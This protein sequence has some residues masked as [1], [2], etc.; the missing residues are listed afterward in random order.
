VGFGGEGA[1]NGQ[2]FHVEQLGKNWGNGGF[3]CFWTGE[4]MDAAVRITVVTVG[5]TV[6]ICRDGDRR[7]REQQQQ[8]IP[9]GND[10]KKKQEQ[11]NWRSA[12]SAWVFAGRNTRSF[13]G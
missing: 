13:V 5:L 9:F 2:L 11:E 1:W 7:L 6:E 8:Q 10:R 3:C 12:D 4:R